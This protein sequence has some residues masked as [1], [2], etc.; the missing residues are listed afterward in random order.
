MVCLCERKEGG[1]ASPSSLYATGVLDILKVSSLSFTDLFEE[2]YKYTS[3]SLYRNFL[4]DHIAIRTLLYKKKVPKI[5]LHLYPYHESG[6][7]LDAGV[8][9]SI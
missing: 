9:P 2:A 8:A 4:K 1:N 6:E 7:C 5:T 3:I